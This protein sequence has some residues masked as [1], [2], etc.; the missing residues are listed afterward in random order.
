MTAQKSSVLPS[1]PWLPH[2][3]WLND[4]QLRFQPRSA[5]CNLARIRFL[6]DPP[7]PTRLPFEMFHCVRDVTLGSINSSF[8][9]RLIHDFSSGSN[10][11]FASHVFV[12]SRLFA[13]QHHHCTLRTFAK[14]RLRRA[15]VE[16][17]CLTIFRRLAHSRPARRVRRL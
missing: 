7:F 13:D 5:G 1:R 4:S 2:Q 11:R 16:V 9:E 6:M 17:A 3:L 10:E 15:L 8:F 14:D 12:I